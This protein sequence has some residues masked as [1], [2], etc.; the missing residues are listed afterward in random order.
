MKLQELR[1]QNN[2]SQKELST[3]SGTALR[4]IKDYEQGYRDINKAAAENLYRLSLVLGCKMEDLLENTKD[5]ENDIL[6]RFS[7]D[8]VETEMNEGSHSDYIDDYSSPLDFYLSNV[9]LDSYI[10]YLENTYSVN[11]ESATL[12]QRLISDKIRKLV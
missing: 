9:E 1:K 5:I 2:L 3:L 10:S 8:A 4:T 12:L 7:N 6:D 11:E